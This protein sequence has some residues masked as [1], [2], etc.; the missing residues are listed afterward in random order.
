M[1][2]QLCAKARHG[3]PAPLFDLLIIGDSTPICKRFLK[4]FLFSFIFRLIQSFFA[5]SQGYFTVYSFQCQTNLITFTFR[6][7]ARP[8]PSASLG[9]RGTRTVAQGADRCGGDLIR[10]GVP[11]RH[12]PHRGRLRF[13][14]LRLPVSATGGGRFRSLPHRGR[15]R[16]PTLHPPSSPTGRGGFQSLPQRGR[17]LDRG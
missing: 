4:S 1:V 15:L 6:L 2:F 12:L 11:P 8:H 16:F 14:T 3:G 5:T 7:R 17:L 9:L 13:P 10:R